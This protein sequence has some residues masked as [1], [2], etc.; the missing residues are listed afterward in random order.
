MNYFKSILLTLLTALLALPALAR[1]FEYNGITYSINDENLKTCYTKSGSVVQA[2]N[3]VEGDI[4]IPSVASDGENEYTVIAIGRYGFSEC[5]NLTSITM[6]ESVTRI[7]EY[8]FNG[9]AGLTSIK[10]PDGVTQ[11]D[12]YAFRNCSDLTSISIGEAVSSIGYNICEG[13]PNLNK[14]EFASI[15]S[16]CKMTFQYPTSNPLNYAHNLYIN[17]KEAIDIVIPES[18][19]KIKQ[20]TFY[21]CSNVNSVIIPNTVTSIENAAF[22][23]CVGLSFISIPESVSSIGNEVFR[24]CSSLTSVA[25]P[26]KVEKIGDY[27]FAGCSSLISASIPEAV[28]SIGMYAFWLCNSLTDINFPDSLTSIGTYAFSGCSSL[29]SIKFPDSLSS[30]GYRAFEE[31]RSLTSVVIPDAVTSINGYLFAKC[32]NLSSVIMGKYVTLIDGNAFS[33]C[34]SIE[35]IKIPESVTTIGYEAFMNCS[36]LASITIPES[37]ISIEDEAFSGCKS[38]SSAKLG[39]SITSIGKNTFRNCIALES[40]NIPSSVTSVGEY[41]FGSCTALASVTYEASVPIEALDNVFSST[42]HSVGM[43]IYNQA[44]L[45]TPNATLADIQATVPWNMF[46]HI[47][48]KDGS[49][50]MGLAVGADFEYNGIW[51]TV[52]DAD[53]KTCQ[54]KAGY[55]DRGASTYV[56]GNTVIGDIVIPS[57]VTHGSTE[58]T[59]TSIG[60]DS[61]AVCED[62]TSIILPE[63]VSSIGMEAFYGCSNLTSINIPEGVSSIERDTFRH[64]SSLTTIQLPDAVTFIGVCAFLG[65]TNLLSINIPEGVTSIGDCAFSNCSGLISID[66][67]A[68]VTSIEFGTFSGCTNLTFINIPDGVTSIGMNAFFGCAN[69]TSINIPN[70]VISIGS[71]AFYECSSLTSISLP[72]GISSIKDGTF[73]G[74]SALTAIILPES[75]TTIEQIAFYGC[76]SLTSINIPDG[77]TSIDFGTFWD[78]SALTNII[79]PEGVTTIESCAFYRCSNLLSINIPDGVTSIGIRAFDDCSN[80]PSITIPDGVTSIGD[81]AFKNCSALTDITYKSST[82]I[83]APEDVFD[84]DYGYASIYDRAIL[85]MP[86]ATLA[87]IQATVPWNM[88]KHIIAKDGSIGMSLEAGEDFEYEGIWY[89]VIDPET[90][91]CKTKEGDYNGGDKISGNK[92]VGNVVIPSVAY[93]GTDGYSVV[94]IGRYSFCNNTELTSISVPESVTAIETD[95]FDHCTNLA[96]ANF[97]SIEAL[98]KINFRSSSSN[99][100]Y[101]SH[102]LFIGGEEVTEVVIPESVTSLKFCVFTGGSNLTSVTFHEGMTTIGGSAFSGCSKLTAIELPSSVTSIESDAFSN[103]TSLTSVNLPEGI[104]TIGNQAFFYCSSL[105]S[106]SLPAGITT[107]GNYAFYECA[108]LSSV[109][110]EA[111][112]PIK[113]NSNIFTSYNDLIYNSATLNMPNATL[114]DIQATVPWNM[115]QHIVAKDG[116]VGMGPE[117]GEDFEYEGIWYT[118][119]G[120]S[121]PLIGKADGSISCNNLLTITRDSGL[122]PCQ[123]IS[124][125]ERGNVFMCEILP[126]PEERW[127]CEFFIKS[128]ETLKA[129]DHINISFMYKCSDERSIETQAH[130]EPRDYNYWKCIGTLD[131]TTEWQKYSWSGVV[132]EEWIGFNGFMS[133]DFLLSSKPEAATFYVDDV[134]FELDRNICSTKPQ[135]DEFAGN[136][137][138]GDLVI[139]ETA[140]YDTFPFTVTAIGDYSFASSDNL[141]SVTIPA[142]IEDFGK[143]AFADCKRLTSLVWKGNAPLQNSVVEAI[144]N[145]NLLIYVDSARFAPA[146]LD[147]NIVV[148]GICGNLVL[149]SGYPFTPVNAFTSRH[150]S[151]TKTF[152]Q[153][154]PINGCAGWET[155]VLPFD[156]TSVYSEKLQMDLTPFAALSDISYQRPYWLY[157]ADSRGGW[158]EVAII[159][160]GVPY[161]ISMPNNPDYVD[162]YNIEGNVTFSN[163][164]PT[165]ITPSTTAPYATTWASGRQ[166]R[167]LW[168]PLD[169]AQATGAMALNVGISDLTDNDGALLAPGSAFHVGIQPR[170]LE[171]YVTRL[172]SETL[173]RISGEQSSVI[174][175]SSDGGLTVIAEDGR[176]IIKSAEDRVIGVYTPD[177]VAVRTLDIKAGETYTIDN[178]TRGIYIV[179]GNKITVK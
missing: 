167:S 84:T 33:G 171:A 103:C 21:E 60:V 87:D 22:Y 106:I 113:G 142:T 6:P 138:V 10:I 65:C 175:V 132:Q 150:S 53:A 141:L 135:S 155:I 168:L 24:K 50:G 129:G 57:I 134:V 78:C 11:I 146:Y 63:S 58:Y 34:T 112:S 81:T 145:P 125:Q 156:V 12:Q 165:L 79:L 91:T 68:G 52:T 136:R 27:L 101:L 174:P 15:E 144:A 98:C 169:E 47:I 51:Y 29:A 3:T 90:K 104:L 85:N 100:L 161:L 49:I 177:G 111:V 115:F 118:V 152:S 43:N 35:S 30:I 114:A 72:A 121:K 59:V 19:T 80:L 88:F 163:E 26:D 143:D 116:S 1:D 97:A 32:T 178:L 149:T 61:F 148:D 126:D 69:L 70:G 151:M 157:E 83:E 55:Y 48:A 73:M 119:L 170:P 8:A 123:I 166:F 76:S 147:R 108:D 120:N 7:N 159:N 36:N 89:T 153:I 107:L 66:I 2:G 39:S 95:A 77:I 16:L 127:D 64:C 20:Y 176:I 9:C 25:I 41:A 17:G 56:G 162:S 110:Y 54:T 13:C 179:A 45:Y 4:I 117:V 128:N 122:Y 154:T 99:P 96:K 42:N 44:I 124:D 14:A 5:V 93:D 164:I 139:P 133:I 75:V 172:G 137:V 31:C 71:D 94:E 130:A 37:V 92:V 67:P 102:H 74:C 158:K 28:T 38:L 173:M 140:Y 109:T 131:A 105:A 86:N 82:P 40:V 18:I 46:Q 23:N 160:A 62:L